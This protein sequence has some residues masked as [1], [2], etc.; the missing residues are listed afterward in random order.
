MPDSPEGNGSPEPE[1]ITNPNQPEQPVDGV[2]T[3]N[4]SSEDNVPGLNPEPTPADTKHPEPEVDVNAEIP[5]EHEP[6]IAERAQQVKNENFSTK[7]EKAQ[8]ELTPEQLTVLARDLVEN[9]EKSAIADLVL[10][11]QGFKN[12]EH[13]MR[14]VKVKSVEI[15]G[16]G[17]TSKKVELDDKNILESLSKSPAIHEALKKLGISGATSLAMSSVVFL[18]GGPVTWSVVAAGMAGSVAGRSL[19]ELWRGRQLNKLVDTEPD[20]EG[21][22]AKRFNDKI[23]TENLS[24]I[25]SFAERA[26]KILKEPD[27][28]NRAIYM[29]LLLEDAK[30]EIGVTAEYKALEKDANKIK[31]GLSLLGAV[32]G[33]LGASQLIG[34][35]SQ[36]VAEHL[37]GSTLASAKT[38]AAE[39]GIRIFHDAVGNAHVTTDPALGHIV[40]QGVDG[41]WHAIIENKDLSGYTD[42]AGHHVKGALE[43]AKELGHKSFKGILDAYWKSPTSGVTYQGPVPNTL[44]VA[45]QT[46]LHLGNI[47]DAGRAVAEHFSNLTAG[48]GGQAVNAAINQGALAQNWAALIGILQSPVTD[49]VSSNLFRERHVP[50]FKANGAVLGRYG[51]DDNNT[52]PPTGPEEAVPQEV[53]RQNQDARELIDNS[54]FKTREK[55]TTESLEA[56]KKLYADR[57]DRLIEGKLNLVSPEVFIGGTKKKLEKPEKGKR[58]GGQEKPVD[59]PEDRWVTLRDGGIEVTY[60][61]KS[62]LITYSNAIA[63]HTELSNP[64]RS[65]IRPYHMG[66]RSEAPQFYDEPYAAEK[67]AIWER[68]AEDFIRELGND[69]KTAEAREKKTK[70]D[71]EKEQKLIEE[72]QKPQKPKDEK[73]EAKKPVMPKHKPMPAKTG[74]AAIET[75]VPTE[76]DEAENDKDTEIT[77]EEIS[78]KEAEYARRI[79][80]LVDGREGQITPQVRVAKNHYYGLSDVSMEAGDVSVFYSSSTASLIFRNKQAD[81]EYFVSAPTSDYSGDRQ[82]RMNEWEDVMENFIEQ[83]GAR[84]GSNDEIVDK[85]T[86][87]P[88]AQLIDEQEHQAFLDSLDRDVNDAP[89][90]DSGL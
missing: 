22:K 76:A 73:T 43:L 69:L 53:P 42:A 6:T 7:D 82:E 54:V 52:I 8:V 79:E 68:S 20:E 71:K 13:M 85:E 39:N 58:A 15:R 57:I 30:K 35:A 49:R 47:P 81:S 19:G 33:S 45:P 41:Q 46:F 62:G 11:A 44:P 29:T 5:T 78:E 31:A 21:V 70:D 77:P 50:K 4:P 66:G 32:G 17:G 1:E 88:I 16:A 55:I 84:L 48:Q 80:E 75:Q 24:T 9:A 28:N 2:D 90:Q 10:S 23:A 12:F 83:L 63:G 60:D 74:R 37:T 67:L 86:G 26:D 40:K 34:H 38:N 27:P 51:G 87:E 56:K 64:P 61:L 89:D 36:K 65:I 3:N 14:S 25:M 72:L 59:Q 18:L